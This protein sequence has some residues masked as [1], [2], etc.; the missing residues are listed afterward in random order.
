[1]RN[2]RVRLSVLLLLI[3][4]VG[5]AAAQPP[6]SLFGPAPAAAPGGDILGMRSET[7]GAVG[8][9]SLALET[10][11]SLAGPSNATRRLQ[12][13]LPGGQ[14][15]T[16][17]L[18]SEARAGMMLLSGNPVGGD[19]RCDL[20]VENGQVIGDVAVASGR[21]R[22]QPIGAGNAHAVVEV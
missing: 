21:Y 11:N 8:R 20:V 10:V 14:S 1:M 3:G 16:C 18:R 12:I 2:K 13:A 5:G 4:G 22:I 15:V 17:E 6:P 7:V 9:F 19:G